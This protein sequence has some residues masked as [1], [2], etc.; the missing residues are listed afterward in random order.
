MFKT[1]SGS[2]SVM[3]ND[4]DVAARAIHD[5]RVDHTTRDAVYTHAAWALLGLACALPVVVIVCVL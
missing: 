5:V 1:N 4:R 3:S 2:S